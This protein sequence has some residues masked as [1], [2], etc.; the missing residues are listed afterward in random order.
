MRR[1]IGSN[2]KKISKLPSGLYHN[3]VIR[4]CLLGFALAL[5]GC[6]TQAYDFRDPDRPKYNNRLTVAQL[7]E[8]RKQGDLTL[9]DVRLPEDFAANPTLIPGAAYLNPEDI[10]SWAAEIPAGTKVVAYCEHGKW[11]SQKAAEYL[12][13]RGLEVYALEGG[14]HAWQQ[15][16]P[17][18]DLAIEDVTVIDAITGVRENQTVLVSDGE[19]LSVKASDSS[20]ISAQQVIDGRG[21]YLIPGLWDMHVHVT[22]E[23]VLTELM[24]KLF[25]DYGVTSVRDTGGLIDRLLPVVALWRDPATIA[26]RIYYSGPLLDGTSVVYDGNDRPEIGIANP[27]VSVARANIAALAAAKVD[28]VKIYELVSPDVFAELIAAARTHGLPIAAHVPLSLPVATAGPQL[29]SMEHLRNVE[30]ACANSATKLLAERMAI[31]AKNPEQLSGHALRSQLHASQRPRALMQINANS[32]QCQSVLRSLRNTIQV[33]TLRLNTISEYSPA[34]RLDWAAKLEAVPHS[35]AHDWMA[36]ARRFADTQQPAN[37]AVMSGAQWSLNLVAAMHKLE[38]PIGAGT[39]TPIAQA[40]PGYSLHTELER[41]VTAGLT[42]LEA[43]GAATVRGAEFFDLTDQTGQ[44]R[45]GMAADL[46][47][48]SANPLIDITNSRKIST[49]ILSGRIVR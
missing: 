16:G 25:L 31:L 14:I 7:I 34:H 46:V 37:S 28:F 4:L 19:I 23:P 6:A 49:V 15:A 27:T 44:I 12:A 32:A 30:L 43:L 35:L 11:V 40:I 45:A 18:Y 47:L 48:L 26:P 24:P 36:T 20:Q 21:K 13:S 8:L 22:Y 29:D 42:P 17:D 39:D 1:T 38:V 10:V 3:R 2:A 9:I 41:L 33:P 5:S